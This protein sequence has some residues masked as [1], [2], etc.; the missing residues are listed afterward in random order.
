MRRPIV[1]S[2][3]MVLLAF[4]AAGNPGAQLQ[5]MINPAGVEDVA[6]EERDANVYP[7]AELKRSR[8]RRGAEAFGLAASPRTDTHAVRFSLFRNH[9][10]P[11][12]IYPQP[13]FQVFQI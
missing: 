11:S 12:S 5:A 7:A 10:H 3:L 13:L 9:S 6:V 2:L 1:L 4:G 8:A